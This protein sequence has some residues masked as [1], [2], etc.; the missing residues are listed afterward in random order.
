M[1]PRNV[2]DKELEFMAQYLGNQDLAAVKGRLL[3]VWRQLMAGPPPIYGCIREMLFLEPK[4]RMHPCYSQALQLVSGAGDGTTAPLWVDIGCAVGTDVRALRMDGVGANQL[5]AIDVTPTFWNAGLQL[6][7]DADH[8][9]CPAV[10]GDI[11]SDAFLPP[12][13]AGPVSMACQPFTALAQEAAKAGNLGHLVGAVQVASSV[14]VLHVLPEEGVTKLLTKMLLLLRPGGLLLGNAMG[15]DSPGDWEVAYH[16]GQRRYLHSA[17]SLHKELQRVGYE[18]V[19]VEAIPWGSE[20]MPAEFWG[21]INSH[22]GQENMLR[23]R[24]ILVFSAWK[25]AAARVFAHCR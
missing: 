5:L 14:A 25:P 12:A 7:G 6:F 22:V 4:L 8:P 10:F 11:T 3:L 9:P 1:E 15:A 21:R 18:R 19:L 16:P 24:Q 20:A 17:G 23:A 13:G 2:D